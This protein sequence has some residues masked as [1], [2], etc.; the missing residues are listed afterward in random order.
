MTVY[1]TF[2]RERSSVSD[3]L[4]TGFA[5]TASLS[6]YAAKQSVGVHDKTYPITKP[7]SCGK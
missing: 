3:T 6:L 2:D 1:N 5:V 7:H 4:S